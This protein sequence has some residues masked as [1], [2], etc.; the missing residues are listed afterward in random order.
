MKSGIRKTAAVIM[1][2]LLLTA[3]G[4]ASVPASSVQEYSHGKLSRFN[5]ELVIDGSGSLVAGSNATDI[6]GLRYDAINLFLSL[7]TNDGNDVGAIVFD[8]KSNPFLLD[9]GLQPLNGKDDKIE[10]SD[11]IRKAGTGNDTDIGSALYA[12]VQELVAAGDDRPS[13]VIL[14][15]DGRTDLGSN[16][17]A[18]EKSLER[19]EE[20][21]ELAQE[22]D[23]PIYTIC[24][25]ASPV[26]DPAELSEIASRT[27][28]QAIE[29]KSAENLS[30]AFKQF[31]TLI[32]STSVDNVKEDAFPDSGELG[33]DFEV[34]AYGAE[35]VNII[36]NSDG[37]ST[38][39]LSSPSRDWTNAEVADSTMKARDYRVIKL[40]DP[41]PGIWHITLNGKKGDQS[42]INILYNVNTEAVL[43]TADGASEYS[44]GE[45]AEL[46]LSLEQE[47]N[48]LTDPNLAKE[49]QAEAT[50]E[51]L[52]TGDV[53]TVSMTP[54]N[55]GA[56]TCELN[57]T[58]Y[59]TYKITAR[60]WCNSISLDSNELQLNFGNSAPVLTDKA[61]DALIKVVVT[62]VTGRKKNVDISKYFSDEQ[63]SKLTYSIV[64]STLVK[65]TAEL[66]GNTLKVKT[67][68]SKSGDVI[69]RATDSQGAY[70]DFKIR[71][72]VTNLTIPIIAIILGAIL[73]ASLIGFAGYKASLPAFHGTIRVS[74]KANGQGI[75]VGAFKGKIKL[76]KCS[77][78]M[79]G[80]DPN[81]TFIE[82]KRNNGLEIWSKRPF[83]VD[84]RPVTRMRLFEGRNEV[85]ADEAQ[86]MGIDIDVMAPGAYR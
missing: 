35:E 12:A 37:V 71:F 11:Q 74:N 30:D 24:L 4:A 43:E 27:N 57:P 25:N 60:A 68:K 47:G 29:V 20:A 45:K 61:K 41:E 38:E 7:L 28:G 6:D 85:W 34:P 77:V 62:P 56:F 49:Y 64:S 63:D 42:M 79:C 51:N 55:N 23:I 13:V 39:K 31:Y 5:I 70:V 14:M 8:D 18:L 81:N 73:I 21:I 69:V 50:F 44:L 17:D 82:A 2:V 76:S 75:P 67:S 1:T 72:K 46:K 15:S 19:K 84:G 53:S 59:S 80:L 10:L 58:D 40:V 22:N 48:K 78:G 16:K 52:S 66:D 65:D 3:L 32:F 54:D 9:T 26:A 86:M 83:F 33:Y 36:I